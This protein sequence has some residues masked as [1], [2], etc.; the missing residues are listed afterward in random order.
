MKAM[1]SLDLK[2]LQNIHLHSIFIKANNHFK[3]EETLISVVTDSSYDT[4]S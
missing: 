4:C 2:F 1:C 3:T